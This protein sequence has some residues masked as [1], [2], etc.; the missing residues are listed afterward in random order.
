MSLEVQSVYYDGT[1]MTTTVSEAVGVKLFIFPLYFVFD[2][3]S[4]L[5]HL[6]RN[7]RR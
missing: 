5:F 7:L 3:F 4:F 1:N 2:F 6:S